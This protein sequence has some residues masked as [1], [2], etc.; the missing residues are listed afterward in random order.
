MSKFFGR[1]FKDVKLK[2]VPSFVITEV[3][4]NPKT[5]YN[6]R[7]IPSFRRIIWSKDLININRSRVTLEEA[8]KVKFKPLGAEF[9]F[10]YIVLGTAP[11]MYFHEKSNSFLFL[12]I[13]SIYKFYLYRPHMHKKII[14]LLFNKKKFYKPHKSIAKSFKNTSFINIHL[15]AH[16]F[17]S[18]QLGHPLPLNKFST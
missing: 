5:F 3:I 10:Y 2:E 7:F 12:F 6:E 16:L 1:S 4:A 14:Y 9:F 13:F 8:E 11:A 15:F 17:F 18:P